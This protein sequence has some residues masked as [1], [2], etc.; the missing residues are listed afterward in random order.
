MA[1]HAKNKA[2]DPGRQTH[3]CVGDVHG[4]ADL[5]APLLGRITKILPS[6]LSPRRYRS[7]SAITS[8]AVPTCVRFWIC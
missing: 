2:A 4:R 3:L 1:S 7:S 8:T 6:T 5:L